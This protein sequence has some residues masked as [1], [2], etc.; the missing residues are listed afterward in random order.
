VKAIG[1]CCAPL[2]TMPTSM[3]GTAE[4]IAAWHRMRADPR[5]PSGATEQASS[6][7]LRGRQRAEE[8][9]ASVEEIGRQVRHRRRGRTGGQRTEKS[10]T[11]IEGLP[12]TQRIDGV[13]NLIQAIAEQTNLLAAQCDDRSRAR[14]GDAGRGF[15]VVAQRGQGVGRADAK[16]N[17]LKS[18]ERRLIQTSTK[19]SSTAVR[20]IGKPCVKQRCDLEYRQRH[21]PATPRPANFAE[22]A[23]GGT[24]QWNAVVNIGSLS[25]AT[26]R[27]APLLF[28]AHASSD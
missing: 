14:A 4:T 15:A 3:R 21:Q 23:T 13:L 11:E 26:A 27:P 24:G 2:P 5:L 7:R 17:P 1:V 25:D 19:N 28:R 8:L 10:I 16:A 6:K 22:R 20:E 9:S 12:R 18:A